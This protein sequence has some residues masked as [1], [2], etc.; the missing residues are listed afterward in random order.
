M[1]S[2]LQTVISSIFHATTQCFKKRPSSLNVVVLLPPSHK[3]SSF[4]QASLIHSPCAP[5]L[6]S[7]NCMIASCLPHALQITLYAS[8]QE[9]CNPYPENA[10]LSVVPVQNVEDLSGMSRREGCSQYYGSWMAPRW[11]GLYP[12]LR[13]CAA[14]R[15][16]ETIIFSGSHWWETPGLNL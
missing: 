13:L 8:E 1:Q 4:L 11:M 9:W 12:L 2:L 14:G 10:C 16:V 7:F 3:A 6:R 5:S 15:V